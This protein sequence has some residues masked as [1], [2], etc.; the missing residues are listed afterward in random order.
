MNV[1]SFRLLQI[2]HSLVRQQASFPA[3]ERAVHCL[4]IDGAVSACSQ[5]FAL[6]TIRS[7]QEGSCPSLVNNLGSWTL[8][9]V[10]ST[11]L[12]L[13]KVPAHCSVLQGALCF[14]MTVAEPSVST[15]GMLVPH[16]S[17]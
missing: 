4:C 1:P 3:Y 10:Q 11:M 6:L 14:L 17:V 8:G 2:D 9:V 13:R 15:Q 12:R 16:S 7:S 5:G